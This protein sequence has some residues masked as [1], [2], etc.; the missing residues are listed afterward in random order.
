MQLGS[1]LHS[2]LER[3][4]RAA[5]PDFDPE[6][7]CAELDQVADHEFARAPHKLGFRPSALW[8]VE[9]RQ[10]KDMLRETIQAL[11]ATG[12]GWRPLAFERKFGLGGEAPLTLDLAGRIV[13]M[14]GLIDRVDQSDLGEIRVID[15]KTG[16]SHL[17]K[18]DFEEG[19][20]LQ[21]PIYALAA[22]NALGLGEVSEAFYWNIRKAEAGSFK[23][24]N[25]KNDQ[26]EGLAGAQTV[27]M[28]HV[29]SIL[30]GLQAGHFPPQPPHGGCPSY[31]PTAVWCWRY[32]GGW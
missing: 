8:A 11:E 4:Y 24:S 1:L 2:I 29:R 23:L 21:L 15:Y 20:R 27:L 28:H 26:G 5:S 25:Y 6:H 12:A 14:R 22:Q 7:L 31:C 30:S 16:G 9:Q 19:R 17:A 10:L 18:R 13:A 3:V 32:Q